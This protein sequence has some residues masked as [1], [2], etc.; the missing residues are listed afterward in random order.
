[1]RYMDKSNKIPVNSSYT[2][3]NDEIKLDKWNTMLS[4]PKFDQA[5][6]ADPVVIKLYAKPNTGKPF[7]TLAKLKKG[8][9]EETPYLSLK[10]YILF[11]DVGSA[12]WKAALEINK[13]STIELAR[14]SMLEEDKSWQ[15]II[16]NQDLSVLVNSKRFRSFGKYSFAFYT[17]IEINSKP[18]TLLTFVRTMMEGLKRKP[19]ED[20]S[21]ELDWE[22]FSKKALISRK[23]V[24]EQ[25]ALLSDVPEF[26][27]D[28]LDEAVGSICHRCKKHIER[29]WVFCPFCGMLI[30]KS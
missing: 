11:S 15:V 22:D 14:A 8:I 1:M 23:E 25:W 26:L 30:N 4:E 29:E 10:S 7:L 2:L 28:S 17:S 5:D 21:G 12:A 18:A 16:K 19:W 3:L 13:T 24:I 9:Y 6:E 20:R 27:Y